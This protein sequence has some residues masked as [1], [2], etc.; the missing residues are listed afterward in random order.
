MSNGITATAR[1]IA[2][3][4]NSTGQISGFLAFRGD[5]T[6]GEWYSDDSRPDVAI[7][8]PLTPRFV[9]ARKV[10]DWLDERANADES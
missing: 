5:G 8:Y 4:A 10:Q 2:K 1:R 7:R 6:G 9:T 3:A